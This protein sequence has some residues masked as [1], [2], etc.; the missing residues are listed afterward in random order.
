MKIFAAGIATESNSFALVRTD[1]DDFEIRRATGRAQGGDGSI[2]N[3]REPWGRLAAE[4]GDSFSLSLM[5]WADPSGITVRKAYET[6][7]DEILHDLGAAGPV[8][9]VLLMLHGAMIADGYEDCEEDLLARIRSIVGSVAVIGVELDLHCHVRDEMLALADLVVTYKEYP[10][11]DIKARAEEL[12]ALAVDT[13][14][15]RIKPVMALVDCKMVGQF[16]TTMEPLRSIVGDMKA[17]E[18]LDG[19]LSISFIHGFRF[20]DVPH[21]GA[22]MLV[23]ADREREAAERVGRDFAQ[24]LLSVR[25][26]I[27][28]ASMS[29]DLDEALTMAIASEEIPVIVADQADNPGSGGPGDSTFALDWLLAN[30]V[31]HAALGILYDPEVVRIAR[32]AGVG[33]ELRLRLGGKLG[34]TSGDPIDADATVTAIAEGYSIALPQEEGT[35]LKYAAG[36]V[37]ALRLSGVDV[38]VN[39]RQVQCFSPTVFEDLGIRLSDR[40]VVVVKSSQHFHGAFAPMAGRIVYMTS[41]GAVPPDPRMIAYRRFDTDG[42]Y[43]WEESPEIRR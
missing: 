35:P 13:R 2:L 34:M 5:A 41:P 29:L 30:N 32:K 21:M 37:V 39:N 11:V 18:G 1:L 10:H 26:E 22:K 3:L 17:A 23:I 31:E 7:R 38:L 43:P 40:Q 24:R 42:H 8:D 36:D 20:G 14:E 12:F 15:G 33:A 19:I 4:R 25:R 27:S 16:P 28:F 6:L 9:I